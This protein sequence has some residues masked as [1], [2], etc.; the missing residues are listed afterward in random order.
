MDSTTKWF[1]YLHLE[2]KLSVQVIGEAKLGV[3]DGRLDIPILDQDGKRIFSKYRKEPWDTTNSPKY[4]YEKGGTVSLYGVHFP[5][6]SKRL[7]ITEGELDVMAIRTCGFDAVTSTGGTLSWQADWKL[8]RVP[9]IIFDNDDAG[10][11]GTIRTALILGKC[12]ISWVPKGFGKDVSEVLQNKGKEFLHKLLD[13]PGRQV[14]LD[15]TVTNKKEIIAKKKELQNLAKYMDDC[16]GRDIV[17]GLAKKMLELE[18]AFTK[19]KPKYE[20]DDRYQNTIERAKQ[21]PIENLIKVVRKMAK[22]PFH[23]NGEEKTPS[24][25]V[26]DNKGFC[27]GGCDDRKPKDAID[28][29]M[30][31]NNCDIKTAVKALNG[32]T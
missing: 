6:R 2:R 27:F 12:V 20:H 23:A 25:H 28:I 10:I 24:F 8:D 4:L 5:S 15:L 3:K 18:R 14:H 16:P 1:N 19:H 7:L 13:D 32:T 30:K 29:Y 11:K 17:V 31:L 21:Y 22:C 26:K 9:M